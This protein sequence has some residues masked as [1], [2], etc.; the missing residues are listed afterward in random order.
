MRSPAAVAWSR[1][2]VS[3]PFVDPSDALVQAR[4]VFKNLT[5]ALAAAG[6]TPADVIKLTFYLTDMADL[7]PVR[8]ARDEFV[9]DGPAPAS[10]LVQVSALVLPET[11]I[12]IDALAVTSAKAK[13]KR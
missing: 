4:Q 3:C 10:S 13:P 11:R 6:A 2:P 9:G 1:Y 7:L 12:E 8:L 5:L